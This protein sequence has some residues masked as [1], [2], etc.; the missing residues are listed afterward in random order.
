MKRGE[1]ESRESSVVVQVTVVANHDCTW[2]KLNRA[3][4]TT[5]GSLWPFEV[6][7]SCGL[8]RLGR[9]PRLEEAYPPD[10][11]G[12]GEAK[13]LPGIEILSH[14]PPALMV[15]A[16]RLA[17]RLPDGAKPRSVLDVG[18]GRGYLLRQF[19]RMGWLASGI[20]IKGSP[21]PVADPDLD[22]R[23]GD[24]CLLP[25]PAGHFDLVVINHVLE[26]VADP[27]TACAE[28]ARVLRPGGILYVGVPN[29]GSFQRRLFGSLWFPLELPRHLYHF[30]PR[31]L[32]AL[33]EK[34]GFTV[35]R[36]TTRSYRQSMFGFIQ[37]ALDFLDRGHP[38]LLLAL[39]KGRAQAFSARS[40]LHISA[41]IL[42]APIAF[43]ETSLAWILSRGSVVIVVCQKNPA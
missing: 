43:V 23:E 18:C 4:A 41:G 33:T 10:Y 3:I 29:Y 1:D 19:R 9:L 13:F 35:L 7:T 37:S 21:I 14:A 42:L 38:G 15:T 2:R 34:A 28:A 5:D 24:A 25:W 20:D 17:S 6:C 30:S 36:Q 22:C 31:S 12:S 40:L 26:H 16:R 32:S 27:W 8:V 39:L 11:Y